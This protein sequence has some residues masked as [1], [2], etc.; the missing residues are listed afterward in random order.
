MTKKLQESYM[1]WAIAL[2]LEGQGLTSPNPMVGAVV[3]KNNKIVG[4]GYH[5]MA[6]SA[7]AEVHALKKAGKLAKGADLYVT[8]EPC[9]HVGRTPPCVDAIIKAQIRRVFIGASDPNPLVDGRGVRM[10]RNSGIK[11]VEGVLSDS[12]EKINDSYNKFI[13]TRVPHITLKAALSM[14]GKIATLNGESK[15]ITNE[16]CRE[17]VHRLR[18]FV[19]AIIIGGNTARIDNPRL[20]VRLKGF[21][22]RG[23]KAVIVDSKL[24]LPLT[25]KLFKRS[26]GNLIVATTNAASPAKVKK[27][28]R[29]G[30]EVV[31]CR[32]T[33]R[34][35][36]DIKDALIKLG[37]MEITSVLVEGGGEM[38][39][40]FFEK[41]F[42]D[43]L[44]I[45]I[46]PKF[47]GGAGLDFLPGVKIKA[48]KDAA[49]LKGITLTEFGDNF[50][51]EGHI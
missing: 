7:H 26:R 27:I 33:S 38:F 12:C 49:V 34:G 6:G 19:D 47:I 46:A 32:K 15:W 44:V 29:M 11:V 9:A 2:A 39:A 4:E 50:V 1:R 40:Q 43:K 3:V 37:R 10:L 21:G 42:L 35:F 16:K 31:V 28:K 20:T 45:C 51:F 41:G 36:V 5:L 18:G 8:L 17:Y 48:M 25:L 23:P 22:G 24:N 30:H 14:D 13:R